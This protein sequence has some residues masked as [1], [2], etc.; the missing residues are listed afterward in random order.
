MKQ[1]DFCLP[2]QLSSFEQIFYKISQL[3]SHYRYFEVW[4]DYIVKLE[5]EEIYA[6]TDLY[7][8]R[9]IFLFRRQG[10]EPTHL[11]SEIKQQVLTNLVGRDCY[12][13][14]DLYDQA[15]EL[16]FVK[17]NQLNLK[18]IV[19]YHNYKETPDFSELNAICGEIEV[20]NPYVCKIATQ[21]NQIGDLFALMQINLRLYRSSKRMIVLGMGELGKILRVGNSLKGNFL[22]FAPEQIEEQTAQGQYTRQEFIELTK[23]LSKL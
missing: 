17:R 3:N 21:C 14:L 4:L 20:L 11:A 6:L 18:L 5:A 1:I 23:L 12:V 15:S 16:S 8:G 22:A 9:L 13:D 7:P 10:L 2:L 19:S